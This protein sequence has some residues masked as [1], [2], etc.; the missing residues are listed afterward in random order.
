LRTWW[1]ACLLVLAPAARGSA[2]A[3]DASADYQRAVQDALQEYQATNFAE[4]YALFEHA[5]RL[6]P[7]A[8]T[9]RCLGMTSFEMSQYVRAQAELRAALDDT[10]QRLTPAQ[11]AEVVGLLDR[12]AHYIATLEVKTK[13]SSADVMLDG[14][15]VAGKITVNLGEH[16]L[17]VR[18]QGYQPVLR[19]VIIEGGKAQSVEIELL[20][21]P[22]ESDAPAPIAQS[23]ELA[24][25]PLPL[26]TAAP[27]SP[28]RDTPVWE[29]W[30][31]WTAIGVVAAGSVA[32]IVVLSS[33]PEPAKPEPGSTG[34]TISALQV[35]W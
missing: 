9:W 26:V 19:K 16:E 30:W 15:T 31:F 23:A 33:D 5:H 25:A 10:R 18:S 29:R 21:L 22:V 7:S 1:L 12:I 34:D 28:P 27:A 4:A 14:Q 24:P 35:R 3:S 2:Q 13:P 8:R 32:A 11:H 20:P 17:A 6:R